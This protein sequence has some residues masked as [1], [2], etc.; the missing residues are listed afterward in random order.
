MTRDFPRGKRLV[1][2]FQKTVNEISPKIGGKKARKTMKTT[3]N[4]A[5]GMCGNFYDP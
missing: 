2:L 3:Q 5:I 4:V 1:A